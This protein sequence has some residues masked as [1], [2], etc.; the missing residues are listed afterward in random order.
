MR[1]LF[2]LFMCFFFT[3]LVAQGADTKQAENRYKFLVEKIK[4][5]GT[6]ADYNE[7][8]QI[9][10]QTKR[11]NP[12]NSKEESL[13]GDMAKAMEDEKWQTCIDLADKALSYNYLYITGHLNASYC[14]SRIDNKEKADFQ[15]YFDLHLLSAA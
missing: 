5:N 13:R 1:F 8:R 10:V 2:N 11:Y 4:T 15:L 14:Y 6:E 7:L 12:Y 3:S 9:F